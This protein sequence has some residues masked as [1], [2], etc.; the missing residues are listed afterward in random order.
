MNSKADIIRSLVRTRTIRNQEEFL[1]LL[2]EKGIL[3]TQATLSRTLK[4]LR[5]S[6]RHNASG[7][8]CYMLPDDSQPSGTTQLQ[9]KRAAEC[10]VSVAFS[11]QMGVIKT[12]PGCANMVGAVIDEHDHP[13]LMG[14]IAGE[15]TLLLILHENTTQADML[16]YLEK[17]IPG[18]ENRL[19]EPQPAL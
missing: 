3:T 17:L 15:N 10:S 1:A 7:H 5:I 6:K 19:I 16:P 2:A 4:K 13:G 12:L 9:G 8:H 11:G 14:T 18:I